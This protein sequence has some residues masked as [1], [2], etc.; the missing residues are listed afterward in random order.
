[1]S[2]KGSRQDDG[3][4]SQLGRLGAYTLHAT[5]DSTEI[6]AAARRTFLERFEKEVDPEGL[7]SPDERQRRALMARRAYFTRLAMRSAKVRRK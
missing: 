5:H 2:A 1:M 3:W 7:L 6:T 4:R